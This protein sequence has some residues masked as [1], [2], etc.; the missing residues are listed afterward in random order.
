MFISD[1]NYFYYLEKTTASEAL[2]KY[3]SFNECSEK[4]FP[5][6]AALM[7]YYSAKVFNFT[8]IELSLSSDNFPFEGWWKDMTIC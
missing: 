6:Q 8:V 2:F 1:L 7:A 3:Y 5:F 4:G